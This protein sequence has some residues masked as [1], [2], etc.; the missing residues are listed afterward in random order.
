MAKKIRVWDGSAWQD[1]APSLP[2]TAIHSAQ[3]SMPLTGVDG[4]VWL[5]TDGTLAGQDFVPLSGGTM[6]GNLNVSSIN[7]GAIS[8]DNYIINGDFSIWQ[9][10]TSFTAG[11]QTADRWLSHDSSGSLSISK[12]TDGISISGT[13]SGFSSSNQ[14]A[15]LQ[16]NGIESQDIYN[17]LIDSPMILS[18][19][20][21]STV[22]ATMGLRFDLYDSSGTRNNYS[23]VI[24]VSQSSSFVNYSIAIPQNSIVTKRNHE[25]GLQFQFVFVETRSSLI[26]GSAT[27]WNVPATY[28][29]PQSINVFSGG[30]ATFEIAEVKLEKGS[31]VTPF[32]RRPYSLELAACQRYYWRNTAT[33]NYTVMGTG[34]A[35]SASN[36]MAYFPFPT[37]MRT[38]PSSIDF[39][40]LQANDSA[41]GVAISNIGFQG[42]EYGPYGAVVNCTTSGMTTYRPTKILSNGSTSG[43]IGFSAE[44]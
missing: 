26:G 19:K 8:G 34:F 36:V 12:T 28:L 24:S 17:D 4:Q 40:T 1:V 10:G 43:Y 25:L 16:Y 35:S 27:A 42:T 18:W 7:S 6:T 21:K 31:T 32:S 15:A 37:T 14:F 30:N 13:Q 41:T 9:R 20:M 5:D 44:L 38:T 33:Q 23:P 3:T 39:S 11:T 2:Y 22:N 29:V